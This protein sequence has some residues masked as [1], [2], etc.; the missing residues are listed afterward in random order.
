M[1][2]NLLTTVIIWIYDTY[3]NFVS[4]P[5]YHIHN[6][7]MEYFTDNDKTYETNGEFWESE[8]KKW[9]SLFN[10]HYVDLNGTNYRKET[11]PENVNKTIVRIKYWYNDKLYKYLTY[12]TNHEWPPSSKPGMVFSIPLASAYLVDADDKPVKDILGKI[13]RYSGPRG[14]FNGEQVRICDMLYYDEETLETMYPKIRIQNIF[15]KT[16]NVC[17]RTGYITDLRVL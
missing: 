9:D 6:S 1:L 10:E 15:G 17:T 5:N 12:N 7:F 16:K 3:K 14:D 2:R 11:V 4:I 8:S 13:R